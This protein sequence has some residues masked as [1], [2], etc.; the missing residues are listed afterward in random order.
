MDREY[1]PES[2]EEEGVI[3]RVLKCLILNHVG[4]K[5]TRSRSWKYLTL[6]L[7]LK[8]LLLQTIR[9]LY[10]SHLPIIMHLNHD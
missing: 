4:R 1:C 8:S 6:S 7:A 2:Q 5:Q 9:G 10:D 3:Y